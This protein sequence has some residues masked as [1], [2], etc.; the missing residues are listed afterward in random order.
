MHFSPQAY[1]DVALLTPPPHRAQHSPIPAL[2][3]VQPLTS[4]TRPSP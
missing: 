3:V 1:P 2:L 4:L